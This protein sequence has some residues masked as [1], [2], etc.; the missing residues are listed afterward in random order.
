MAAAPGA[1][2]GAT[3]VAVSAGTTY[4]VMDGFGASS[5]WNSINATEAQVLFADDSSLPVANT[6]GHINGHVGLSL[7]RTRIDPTG[8]FGTEEANMTV[9]VGVN[10]AIRIWSTEWSPP[11]QYKNNDNVNG[12]NQG[13]GNPATDSSS[14]NGTA[15]NYSGYSSY[16]VNYVNNVKSSTGVTLYALSPQNEPDWDPNYEACLWTAQNFDT[17]VGSYLGPAFKTAGFSTKIIITESFGDKLA[18]AA[19]A[20]DDANAAPYVGIVAGHLYGAL[21]SSNSTGT[22]YSALPLSSGNFTQL[23]SQKYWETEISDVTGAG[24]DNSMTS[25]LEEAY[26]IHTCVADWGMSAFHHWWI[27]A[28]DNSGLVSGTN[29]TT[30][31][32]KL[33]VLGNYSKFI[34][35]GFT[36]ISAT[37]SPVT[38]VSCSAYYNG[39]RVVL[40]A[41]NKGTSA[42]SQAFSLSGM[43]VSSMVPW[44][45]DSA[46]A[47]A[48]QAAVAVSSG[49]F[50]FSLP[51]QSVVTLV[52]DCVASTP[53]FTPIASPTA[54]GTAKPTGTAS[55][56]P[57]PSATEVQSTA[58]PTRTGTGTFTSSA[59][60]AFTG[61]L[62]ATP[63]LSRSATATLTISATTSPT[64]AESS[65][66]TLTPSATS[67]ASAT[68]TISL[69][70]SGTPSA[71][72]SPTA[73]ATSTA[74]ASPS[75]TA[76]PSSSPTPTGSASPT[77]TGSPSP[78]P[79][80]TA[81]R[82]ATASA[83]L[84]P[85]PTQ[86]PFLSASATATLVA[87]GALD[88]LAAEPVPNPN[89]ASLA[90][91]LKGP[92]D[93]V[94]LKVYTRALVLAAKSHASIALRAGWN[95]VPL[96]AALKGL[97]RGLYFIRVRA[98]RAGQQSGAVVVKAMVTQPH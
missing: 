26:W 36:R 95:Q 18:L 31:S 10:P 37:E 24:V 91:K 39:S 20:M 74:T 3:T 73:S 57:T 22:F 30:Y 63:T 89:P 96:G 86:T 14:F 51:A 88:I 1:L 93:G 98:E 50:T 27:N 8:N 15:A 7:L 4:Q 13:A 33:Y 2:W 47:L 44:V 43:A 49:S 25:A 80:A 90:I 94:E 59:T 35:P 16:L 82:T 40:V 52:G 78:S 48:Q 79:S 83:T 69:S 70:P 65:T 87:G 67:S 29:D 97:P 46:S 84:T 92:A 45:T 62:T 28:T 19:T 81:S 23:T 76:E 58:S 77:P 38:G 12:N 32:D 17:F 55:C 56:T 68:S 64:A 66:P 42:V 85:C 75:S 21:T 72:S 61:T 41:I 5:A 71:S 6:A 60:P 11:A 34:R 53:T 54:T 9:A